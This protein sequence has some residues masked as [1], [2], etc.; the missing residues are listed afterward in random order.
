MDERT[1]R[2]REAL[3]DAAEALF[4]ERGFA[5]VSN[6]ELV[7]RAGV[8][9]AAIAYH[10]ESKRGLYLASVQ[11]L[12]CRPEILETWR[13]LEEE[14]TSRPA[15]ARMLAEFI[16]ELAT[17]L[18]TEPELGA[19]AAF[20]LRE[21]MHPSEALPDLVESFTEPHEDLVA[22]TIAA[23]APDFPAENLRLAARSIIGQVFHQHLFRPFFRPV[24]GS[25]RARATQPATREPLPADEIER[26]CEHLIRFS[27]RGLGLAPRAVER[28]V[29]ES[30]ATVR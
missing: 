29:T 22:R 26:I 27:L 13:R 21:A 3:L 12:F 10:F 24:G 7:A 9:L 28:A 25:S 30:A 14:P 4:S 20:M 17:R 2:T 11:R 5:G 19:C 15:A 16:R 8:N 6:R 18:L 23:A 1:Q